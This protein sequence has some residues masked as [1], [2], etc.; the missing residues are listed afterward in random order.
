MCDHPDAGEGQFRGD[1]TRPIAAADNGAAAVWPA[2]VV[3]EAGATASG[4]TMTSFDMEVLPD[5]VAPAVADK[6]D[7]EDMEAADS[8][9]TQ[10]QAPPQ[11]E[12]LE[13]AELG[14]GSTLR[15][16]TRSRKITFRAKEAAQLAVETLE[17]LKPKELATSGLEQE[18][19]RIYSE[20][21][22]QRPCSG[23]GDVPLKIGC[24][25]VLVRWV[26]KYLAKFE[27]CCC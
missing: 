7:D 20:L 2:A 9:T 14:A 21:A 26:E 12:T 25:A 15:R 6:S 23:P 24:G 19:A 11:A 17:R 4:N 22:C 8:V 3:P 18:A 27:V 16:S 1:V 10:S 13:D 5:S